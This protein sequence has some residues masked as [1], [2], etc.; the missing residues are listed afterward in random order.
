MFN[1][2]RNNNFYVA[3]PKTFFPEEIAI[4]YQPFI[5]RITNIHPA[6]HDFINFHIM[7]ITIPNINFEPVVQTPTSPSF[8]EDN[9]GSESVGFRDASNKHDLIDKNFTVT[10][11]AVD[12]YLNYWVMLE[13][14]LYWYAYPQKKQHPLDLNVLILDNEGNILFRAEFIKCM[15]TGLSEFEL[16]YTSPSDDLKTFDCTFAFNRFDVSFIRGDK[17][18]T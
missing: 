10:M 4:R 17:F 16:D 14:F 2:S 12:G 6:L 8:R 15:I 9:A 13:T 1:N 7:K 5:N 3:F 11:G 18:P